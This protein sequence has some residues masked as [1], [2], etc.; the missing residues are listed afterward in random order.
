MKTLIALIIIC[1]PALCYSQTEKAQSNIETMSEKS[2][3]LFKKEFTRIG[4]Y[5]YGFVE[6]LKITNLATINTIKGIR[7]GSNKAWGFLDEDEIDG[8][9]LSLG[10]MKEVL[11]TP[12]P[13]D[14]TEYVFTSKSGFKASI[15]VDR[16][17]WA[18]SIQADKYISSSSVLF[19]K[20]EQF[21]NFY[22]MINA[23]KKAF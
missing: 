15:F 21:Q 23:A 11:N 1:L 14:Y 8:L 17:K 4:D 19:D 16:N 12:V 22:D 10:K 9:I 5:Y 7:I 13:K 2:G 18:F 20:I 3:I 6:V